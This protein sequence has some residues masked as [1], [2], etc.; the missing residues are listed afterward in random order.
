MRRSNGHRVPGESS[1]AHADAIL[2]LA[3]IRDRA[4]TD[5]V[6]SGLDASGVAFALFSPDD[7]LS[8]GSTA[9]AALFDV[10][11]GARTFGDI[12][13][14]CHAK[15]VGPKMNGPI[16]AFL[17]MAAEK[18]RS[19]PHRSFEID[20]SDDRWF[21]VNET[22]LA[23]GWLWS[24]FTDITMLK[25][26]ERV[27][28]LARDAAQ[29]AADTDPLTGLLNRRA[30]MERLDAEMRAAF[31]DCTQLSLVLIDLDHF[32][33]IN[34]RYGHA[35]GDDVLRHFAAAGRQQLRGGDVF[36]R[37]GGEEFMVLMP[38]TGIRQATQAVERLRSHVREEEN[39]AGLCCT[40]TMSAGVAEYCGNAVE[41]LFE[42]A[43]RA[44]YSAKHLGRDRIEQAP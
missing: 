24:V 32:K 3:A 12:L 10:Q 14:H 27:L 15:G 44:L 11:P 36:A 19:S 1:R 4:T 6:L 39:R 35:K 23:D 13:R 8:Y 25:S 43:D 42:R 7:E 26:T 18:R 9:F 20:I 40:Y 28:Q 22:L 33:T 29:L 5:L 17:A 34:D 41:D 31:R 38:G 30:A 21:L 2:P 37:I 16:D